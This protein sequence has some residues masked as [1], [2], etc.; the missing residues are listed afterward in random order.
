MLSRFPAL[1][2]GGRRR[3]NSTFMRHKFLVPTVRKWLI[4]VYI[5]GSYRKIKIGVPLFGRS[6]W[7]RSVV[8]L[9]GP[10]LRPPLPPSILLSSLPS[11][12]LPRG[13]G[14]A[15]SPAVKIYAVKQP[16]KMHIDV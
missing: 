10:G 14:R 7:R 1:L 15:R 11:R 13:L 4:S 9:G 12:G 8:N 5:Y 6:R 3:R 2:L 16:Y